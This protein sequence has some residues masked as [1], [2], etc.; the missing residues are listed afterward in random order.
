MV[1]NSGDFSGIALAARV[2]VAIRHLATDQITIEK[3]LPESFTSISSDIT[4]G[5]AWHCHIIDTDA[6]N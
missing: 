4:K 5:F 3:V 2:C 6:E 1:G